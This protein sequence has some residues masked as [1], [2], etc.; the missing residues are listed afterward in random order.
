MNL[1]KDLQE[2][3]GLSY[4][5]ISHDLAAVKFMS[6]R[7]MVMQHGQMVDDFH[8]EHLFSENRHPYT[9]ELIQMFES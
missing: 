7:I 2:E 1:L 3:L 9:K 4:L 6:Q 5:F 8:S